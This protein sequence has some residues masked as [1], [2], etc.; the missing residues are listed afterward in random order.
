MIG[1]GALF[2]S[3]PLLLSGFLAVG[4]G[5]CELYRTARASP[6]LPT[7]PSHFISTVILSLRLAFGIAQMMQSLNEFNILRVSAIFLPT[8]QC[9]L[10]SSAFGNGSRAGPD[11]G[12]MFGFATRLLQLAQWPMPLR[13]VAL[14]TSAPRVA[15]QRHGA[16]YQ[17]E[18]RNTK[19]HTASHVSW[20][21]PRPR[22][23]IGRGF[24]FSSCLG[25]CSAGDFVWVDSFVDVVRA[26]SDASLGESQLRHLRS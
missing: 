5:S 10:V 18:L 20:Q 4:I 16:W 21:L 25:S 17:E 23:I 19:P 24:R 14:G 22:P 15:R 1:C 3:A 26:A 13:N 6:T 2:A 7:T 9:K 12:Q 11:C 8:H